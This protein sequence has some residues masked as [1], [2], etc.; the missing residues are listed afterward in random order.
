MS[1]GDNYGQFE[2]DGDLWVEDA[3]AP[4]PV[5]PYV[6]DGRLWSES[7]DAPHSGTPYPSDLSNTDLN[8]VPPQ[9]LDRNTI[10][11][12][13]EAQAEADAGV[14]PVD[15]DGDGV[16]DAGEF[17]ADTDPLDPED[18]RS[19]GWTEDFDPALGG[20]PDLARPAI[21]GD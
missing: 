21:L 8:D 19:R 5:D 4:R 6:E 14:L 12:A 9:W 1:G 15:T 18:H 10:G 20:D 16:S 2:E 3:T 7:A 11:V 13:G 17:V